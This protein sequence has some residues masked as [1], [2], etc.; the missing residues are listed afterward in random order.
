MHAFSGAILGSGHDAALPTVAQIDGSS[1]IL[2]SSEGPVG[3]WPLDRVQIIEVGN[4]HFEVVAEDRRL[5]LVVD[6]PMAFERAL[7]AERAGRARLALVLDTPEEDL[8]GQRTGRRQRPPATRR[9]GRP[10][11]FRRPRH[12]RASVRT[13]PF[14]MAVAA[15]VGLGYLAGSFMGDLL[16]AFTA[17]DPEVSQ[18]PSA[19]V[20]LRTFQG[21]G[22]EVTSPF[23]VQAPWEIRWSF[24]ASEGARLEVIALTEDGAGDTVAVDGRPGSGAVPLTESGTFHLEIKS[25]PGGEWTVSVIQVA[26]ADAG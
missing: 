17:E 13:L 19:E 6:Q 21:S 14:V 10:G 5:S 4:G 3:R 26:N 15:V 12:G 24:D 18:T 7:E 20:T 8:V 25:P 22:H 1:L 23:T 16:N 2:F 9:L 11:F